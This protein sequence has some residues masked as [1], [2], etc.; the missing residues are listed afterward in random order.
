M[1]HCNSLLLLHMLLL[2]L[3]LSLLLGL[4][5]LLLLLL[6]LLMGLGLSHSCS[7][8]RVT[9]LLI[10]HLL[11]L[12]CKL[13][14]WREVDERLTYLARAQSLQLG[15]IHVCHMLLKAHPHPA[16]LLCK[17]LVL[18]LLS[19]ESLLLC[20]PLLLHHCRVHCLSC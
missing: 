15:W 7:L 18:G 14:V 2:G 19:H 9:L 11:L 1:L 4:L 12:L 17:H 20:G 16:V 10:L 8:I 6:G 5:L 13:Q 3:L